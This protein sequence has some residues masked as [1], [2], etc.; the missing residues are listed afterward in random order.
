MKQHGLHKFR[1]V[2]DKRVAILVTR[3]NV[4]TGRF[5]S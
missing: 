1:A 2:S 3:D 5:Y 4:F